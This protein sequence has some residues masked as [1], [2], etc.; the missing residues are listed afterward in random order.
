MAEPVTTRGGAVEGSPA[1]RAR[2]PCLDAYR[3]IAMFM[4]ILFHADFASLAHDKGIFGDILRRFDLALAFFFVLSAFLL[5]RPYAA[6]QLAGRP[7]MR[8]RTFYRH[9]LLRIFPGYWFVLL[10]LVVLFG[11][12]FQSFGDLLAYVFILQTYTGK[13]FDPQYQMIYQAWSLATELAFYALLPLFALWVRR[14]TMARAPGEQLRFVLVACGGGFVIGVAFRIFMV[15]TTPSWQESGILSLPC[16]L[17]FFALGVALAAISA[18]TE[19]TGR[20]F[21]VIAWLGRHPAWSWTIAAAVF[22]GATR[23]HPGAQPLELNGVEYVTRYLLYAVVAFLFLL[24]GMFGN[25]YAGPIRAVLRSKPA[26][27]LG[28]IS[29]GFY[30]FHVAII[31][32]VQDWF[33]WEPFAASFVK[34]LLVAIPLSLIAAFISYYVVERPFLR[35]KRES[36][37]AAWASAWWSRIVHR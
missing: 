19:H 26:V 5:F 2:F 15:A 29:L 36:F 30:L 24:P 7:A 9:R 35:M 18:W 6:A 10:A 23:F 22:F 32:K 33:G 34:L 31:E 13:V 11:L 25:Q 1:S 14:R 12:R 28:T 16:W 4:V 17:D 8:V 20:D 37:S 21:V 27:F 3:A